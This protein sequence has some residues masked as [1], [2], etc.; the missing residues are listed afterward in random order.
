M[1]RH[2]RPAFVPLILLLGF[3]PVLSPAA[4]SDPPPEWPLVFQADFAKD[5]LAA[6]EPTDPKVW[7]IREDA[8]RK[9]LALTGK[10]QY[11]PPVRSPLSFAL[12]KDLKASD[13]VL[14]AK[15]RSTTKDYNHRDLCLIFGHGD[16]AH[17]YYVHFAIKSDPHANSIFLVDGKPR[18]SI[19]KTRTDGT[20]WSEDYHTIRVV[21]RAENGS[22]EVYFDD[23]E[24]P[25]MT[26]EDKTFGE[27]RM[28][29]GSFDDTGN[30]AEFRVW[31]KPA[32]ESGRR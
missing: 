7:E 27:G 13:F 25:A 21:R 2:R 28:G 32:G 5:G 17:F 22:I 18:V 31:A 9:V 30:L 15:V 20:R 3:P 23:M 26:A 12:V 16:P 8:G 11:E 1:F 24:T 19:A 4:K 10:S 14:E 6:W 29:F